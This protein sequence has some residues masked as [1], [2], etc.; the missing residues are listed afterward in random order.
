MVC[1]SSYTSE[2]SQSVCCEATYGLRCDVG[3]FLFGD[4]WYTNKRFFVRKERLWHLLV[5][6]I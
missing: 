1:N 5:K 2:P 3:L 6:S 4:M